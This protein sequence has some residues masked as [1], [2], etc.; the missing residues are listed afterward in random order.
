MYDVYLNGRKEILVV[1][2]G[3]DLPPEVGGSWRMKKRWVRVVSEEIRDD[4]ER[5][6]YHQ[7]SLDAAPGH[8]RRRRKPLSS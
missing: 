6:G 8:S 4:V 2:R 3:K 1:A 5:R 7:R